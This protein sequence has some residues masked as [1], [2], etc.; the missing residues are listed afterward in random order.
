MRCTNCSPEVVRQWFAANHGEGARGGEE[1]VTVGKHDHMATPSKLITTTCFCT[2]GSLK[3]TVKNVHSKYGSN[4]CSIYG[5]R[6][7][8][9]HLRVPQIGNLRQPKLGMKTMGRPSPQKLWLAEDFTRNVQKTHQK[10]RAPTILKTAII[11]CTTIAHRVKFLGESLQKATEY[12]VEELCQH[13]GTGSI[14]ALDSVG[15][16]P[17]GM[18]NHNPDKSHTGNFNLFPR[19]YPGLAWREL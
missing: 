15:N 11:K 9:L 17:G 10:S 4:T 6:A 18:L 16:E 14:I 3:N 19:K 7:R 2:W 13:R 8:Q 5:T 12:A 1:V